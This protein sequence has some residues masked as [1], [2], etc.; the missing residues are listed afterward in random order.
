[1]VLPAQLWQQVFRDTFQQ[2]RSVSQRLVRSE[3]GA[4]ALRLWHEYLLSVQAFLAAG[5][6]ADFDGLTQHQ[7]QCEV[8]ENLLTSQASVLLGGAADERGGDPARLEQLNELHNDTLRRIGE[9]HAAA[10]ARLDLWQQYRGTQAGL[11][12][13]LAAMERER[14]RLQL[15]YI[16]LRRLPQLARRINEL[17]DKVSVRAG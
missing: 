5:L 16:A 13:W 3:D 4:A 11:L 2:Y 14:G 12:H 7:H 17:L 15:R 1:M 9:R 10:R 6:P 8:H